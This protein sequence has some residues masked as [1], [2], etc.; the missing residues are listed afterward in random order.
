M[1]PPTPVVFLRGFIGTFDVRG[2]NGPRPRP[3][4]LGY[5]AHRATPPDTIGGCGHLIAAERPDALRAAIARI[6]CKPSA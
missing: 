2:W 4:L 5:G 3:D 1:I 6:V